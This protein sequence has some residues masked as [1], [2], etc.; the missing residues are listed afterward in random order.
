MEDLVRRAWEAKTAVPGFNTPYLPVM[1]ATVRALRDTECLGFVSVARPEW[2][3]FEAKGVREIREEYERVKDERFTR[4]HLDHVPVIDE[5]GERVDHEPVFRE[6]LDL[7][8]HSVMVDGS[9]LPLDENI[10]ATRRI[11]EMAHAAGVPCEAELG[12]IMGHGSGP[13]PPYEEL[14]RS[15]RGFTKPDEAE[16]FVRETG[17][18]WLSVAVGTV[19]GAIAPGLKDRAKVAAKIDIAHLE[20][21]Q[22]AARVPIVL[23]GGTGVPREYVLEAIRHGIAKINIAAA[24]RQPYERAIGESVE[25]AQQAVHEAAVRVIEEYGLCGTARGLGACRSS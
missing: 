6:A 16:R 4:L 20:R 15:G 2:V 21:L 3:K 17:V 19:H 24:T 22:E 12:A 23:H 8:Y 14:F 13:L 1:E 10:R 9:R 18:D 7:G 11:V 25:A 5:D